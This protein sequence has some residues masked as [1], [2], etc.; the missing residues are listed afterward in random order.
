VSGQPRVVVIG[1]PIDAG[2]SRPGAVMGPTALRL[3]GLVESLR[4]L[5]VA[6]EDRGDLPTPAPVAA[7]LGEELAEKARNLPE[8]AAW[9]RLVSERTYAVAR[10]GAFPLVLGGDHSLSMGS[11]NGVA[12]H[13]REIGRPLFVLWLD[14]HADFNTPVTTPS[15]NMHGM[16]AALLVGEPGLDAM[17]RDETR[18][19]IPP[20]QLHLF[21]IRSIDRKERAL[22]EVRGV[23]VVD[24]R[25][26]DEF[27]VSVPLRRVLDEVAAAG[28]LLHPAWTWTS[29]IPPLR[30]GS[31]PRCRVAPPT[32][33]R[34]S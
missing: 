32:G 25:L 14:A 29:W 18:A 27:G 24:M 7:P 21:G 31:A 9:S 20:S 3:A 33:R 11:V 22:L 4:E 1:V 5:D 6:V 19:P 15:G 10:D 30:P 12:R 34:I 13:A 28:G 26:I 8:I 2:A 17:F 23:D 16:S